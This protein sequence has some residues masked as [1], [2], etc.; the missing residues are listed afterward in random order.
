MPFKMTSFLPLDEAA[1]LQDPVLSKR[2][3]RAGEPAGGCR[4]TETQMM[5]WPLTIARHVERFRPRPPGGDVLFSR[6]LVIGQASAL[7]SAVST[8][9][10]P[11]TSHVQQ[12]TSY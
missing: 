8:E 3:I 4:R 6:R 12:L 7:Q 5:C 2:T 1:W 9:S 10:V 11:P